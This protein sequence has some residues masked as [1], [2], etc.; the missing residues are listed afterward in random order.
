MQFDIVIKIGNKCILHIFFVVFAFS[1]FDSYIE[2]NRFV[3]VQCFSIVLDVFQE[4][5]IC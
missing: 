3:V 2:H 4:K 1:D 5:K